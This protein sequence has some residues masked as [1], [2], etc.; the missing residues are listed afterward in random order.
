[1]RDIPREMW[2][3]WQAMNCTKEFLQYLKE[4]I[5]V[6][7]EAWTTGMFTAETAEGTAQLNAKALGK[8]EALKDLQDKL[9]NIHL[10]G[11]HENRTNGSLRFN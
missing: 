6:G 3:E 1:M 2:I 7:K 10:E 5:E 4:E 9:E 11:E 8:I